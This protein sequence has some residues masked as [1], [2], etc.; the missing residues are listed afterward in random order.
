MYINPIYSISIIKKKKKKKR[1]I[2]TDSREAVQ[3][4]PLRIRKNRRSEVF[5]RFCGK[6]SFLGDR[7]AIVKCELLSSWM[8]FVPNSMPTNIKLN[9]ELFMY[10]NP[11]YSI[12]IIKKKKKKKRTIKTDS[13]EAVQKRPLRIRK[14][15]RSEVFWR[16]CGKKSFLG[17]RRAIVKCELPSS[18]MAFVSNS[19]PIVLLSEWKNTH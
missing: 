4:R 3:K 18:W 17:D 16:F 11:I 19:M 12:S 5:W 10:I 15:R 6:K 1:T 14:N 7:R 13:R 2:K 8:A 9:E